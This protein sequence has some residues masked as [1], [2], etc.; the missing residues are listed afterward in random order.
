MHVFTAGNEHL[1]QVTDDGGFAR[2]ARAVHAYEQAALLARKG[3]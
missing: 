3:S 2:T 1:C